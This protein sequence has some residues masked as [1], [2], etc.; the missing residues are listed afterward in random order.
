MA[1]IRD[2]A[3][4]AQVSISTVSRVLN[5]DETLS[6]NAATKKRI[7]EMA[8]ELEYRSKNQ[9]KRKKKLS[10][11][12]INY[13]SLEGEVEDPYYISVRIAIERRAAKLGYR[14]TS[15]SR[16]D[17]FRQTGFDGVLCLGTFEEEEIRRID[18]LGLPT[19]FVDSNPDDTK[20][21]SIAFEL[22]RESRRILNYLWDCG[23]RKIGFIGG[24]DT[25][26]TGLEENPDKRTLE[27][28]LFMEEKGVYRPEYERIGTFTSRMGNHFMYELMALPD[29]PT[30]VFVANDSLAI[31]CLNAI[32]QAGKRC[33]EDYSVVGFNDIPTAK[34]MVPPLTTMRLYMD[35]MGERAV[36]LLSDRIFTKRELP[37]QITLPA[38]LMI[39]E[40]VRCLDGEEK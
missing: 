15:I 22:R 21:D 25:E 23:H 5:Y 26:G 36:D 1:T 30:A 37:M 7:F 17:E 10:L 2:I 20:Y 11:L 19:V 3:E 40:S 14:L 38:K 6:V 9:K 16:G 13:Y 28:R 39:R 31:G 35:F 27:Y 32:S 33:P 4:K 29:P 24:N 18:A 8:E 12:L 34:Y